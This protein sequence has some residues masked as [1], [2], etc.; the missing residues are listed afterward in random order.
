MNDPLIVDRQGDQ[1]KLE[2]E[3]LYRHLAQRGQNPALVR[4][5]RDSAV[6]LPAAALALRLVDVE[7]RGAASHESLHAPRFD[8]VARRALCGTA[9]SSHATTTS[10]VGLGLIL[11]STAGAA[12]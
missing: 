5:D 6:A 3:N 4:P 8:G 7:S 9:R 10:D 1:T 12:T 11:D 2:G